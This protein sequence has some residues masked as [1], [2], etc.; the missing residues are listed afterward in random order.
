MNVTSAGEFL[1]EFAPSFA[2][3][4]VRGWAWDSADDEFGKRASWHVGEDLGLEVVATVDLGATQ[5][6]L[7]VTERDIATSTE[8]EDARVTFDVLIDFEEGLLTVGGESLAYTAAA[9]GEAIAQ[10]NMRA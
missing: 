7:T 4:E 6:Q 2:N 3:E 8:G 10:F 1:T 9:I 5:L